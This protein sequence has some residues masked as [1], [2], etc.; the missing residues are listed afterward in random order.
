FA[1]LAIICTCTRAGAQLRSELGAGGFTQPVAFVQ[2]PSDSTVQVVAQQD[3]RI[4]FLK[5]STVQPTDYLALRGVVRNSGEQ[6]LL[7]FAFAPD[8]A[9]TGRVFVNFI[10]LAGHTVIARF[11]RNGAPGLSADLAS[12]FD[13]RWPDGQRFITQPFA[14][15]NGGNLAF[16]PDVPKAAAGELYVLAYNSGNLYRIQPSGAP[17]P[18]SGRQRPPMVPATG[19]AV[20]RD[21][22]PG[23]PGR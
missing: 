7:G 10:N 3:G 22:L 16:G 14:N 15:H 20:P 1:A 8:Y 4:R 13:L 21:N 19:T 17:L 11:T 5:N 6:G 18:V 2:D 9:S 12:R 23:S